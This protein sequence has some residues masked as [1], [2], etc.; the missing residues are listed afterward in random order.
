MALDA[1]K[2]AYFAVGGLL[3]SAVAVS[4]AYAIYYTLWKFGWGIFSV[5]GVLIIV[6]TAAL[7]AILPLIRTFLWLPE[8]LYWWLTGTDTFWKW[9]APGFYVQMN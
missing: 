4:Y 1:V 7:A 2:M 8:L 5:A 3:G 9:L 6:S